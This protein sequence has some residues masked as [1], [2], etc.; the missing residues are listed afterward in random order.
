MKRLIPTIVTLSLL[1]SSC[2]SDAPV[3]AAVTDLALSKSVCGI[4]SP[5]TYSGKLDSQATKDQ[6]KKN[7]AKRDAFC[8]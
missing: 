5:L 2:I 8:K 4:W 7:N 6:I 3:K 1:L